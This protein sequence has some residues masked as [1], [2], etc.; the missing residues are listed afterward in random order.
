[1][2]TKEKTH[3]EKIESIAS[4]SDLKKLQSAKEKKTIADSKKTVPDS[5]LIK[6]KLSK[7][8]VQNLVEKSAKNRNIWKP[9]FLRSLSKS[10]KTARRIARTQYQNPLSDAVC[11][12]K[13]NKYTRNA[14]MHE[15]CTALRDF[16]ILA[17]IDFSKYSSLS[18]TSNNYEI[19]H[20][21]YSTMKKELK[22]K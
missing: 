1:M 12:K 8:N 22:M 20:T 16:Y 15:L 18:E 17:L 2:E 7:L 3:S 19:V 14:S 13:D 11:K 21:A 6:Q 10:D 5:D 4:A 9:E